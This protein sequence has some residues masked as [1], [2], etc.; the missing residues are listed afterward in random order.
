MDLLVDLLADWFAGQHGWLATWFAK[1][2]I[3][4]DPLSRTGQIM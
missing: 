4:D 2:K 3:S 1:S